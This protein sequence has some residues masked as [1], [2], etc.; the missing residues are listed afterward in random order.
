MGLASS[1]DVIVRRF[2]RLMC[3]AFGHNIVLYKEHGAGRR[4]L[5]YQR[6]CK[7]CGQAG[8][9]IYLTGV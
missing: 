9:R 8:T 3:W 6:R 2:R 5:S 7:R 1:G 4:V